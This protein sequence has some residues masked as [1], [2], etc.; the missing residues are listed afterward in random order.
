MLLAKYLTV[1]MVTQVVKNCC[2]SFI[3]PQCFILFAHI[4]GQEDQSC[5]E[6]YYTILKKDYFSQLSSSTPFHRK[7]IDPILAHRIDH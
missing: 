2:F 6:G 3:I 4:I 1:N 7:V 5:I